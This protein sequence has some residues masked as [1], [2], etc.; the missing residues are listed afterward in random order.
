[1]PEKPVKYAYSVTILELYAGKDLVL[2]G[3]IPPLGMIVGEPIT[4]PPRLNGCLRFDLPLEDPSRRC[5]PA[6]T[7]QSIAGIRLRSRV[8]SIDRWFS[9]LAIPAGRDG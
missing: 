9:D 7:F 5:S 8:E 4:S 1:M 6:S 2:I 3:E